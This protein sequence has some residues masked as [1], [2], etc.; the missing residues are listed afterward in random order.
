MRHLQRI[1]WG[2]LLLIAA[3]AFAMWMLFQEV[4]EDCLCGGDDD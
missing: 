2:H 3:A 1:H 4:H